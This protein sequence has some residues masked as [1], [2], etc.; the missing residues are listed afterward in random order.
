MGIRLIKAEEVSR[1]SR[2]EKKTAARPAADDFMHTA[3]SWVEEFKARKSRPIPS[4][5]RDD[6]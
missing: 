1:A 3:Q 6:K 4:P 2:E 5:F